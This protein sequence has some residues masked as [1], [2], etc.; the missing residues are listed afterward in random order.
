MK[1]FSSYQRWS[2]DT[3]S[4]HGRRKAWLAWQFYH[5]AHSAGWYRRLETVDWK[6][7]SRL[8][9][10]CSGNVCRSAYADALASQIGLQSAS[11]GLE[12]TGGTPADPVAVKVASRRGLD[13]TRHRSRALCDIRFEPTDLVVAHEP[14]Q[15]AQLRRKPGPTD[16]QAQLTL[17]GLWGGVGPYVGDPY[18]LSGA[19][20]ETCFS[21]IDRAVLQ[22]ADRLQT[23][24]GAQC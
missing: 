14:A 21:I 6:N 5:A 15:V 17:M 7:V 24:I 2:A 23:Q 12:A 4:R 13:L 9:F 8:V 18:G 10:V 20:F 19:Y 1:L 16:V 11:C 22:M 3:K